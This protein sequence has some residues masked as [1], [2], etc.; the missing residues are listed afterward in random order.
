MSNVHMFERPKQPPAIAG[1]VPPHNLDAE[2][3]VLSTLMLTGTKHLDDVG[4]VLKSAD[5]YGEANGTVFL[6]LQGLQKAG[7]PVDVV[8]VAGWLR[9][10]EK[11]PSCGGV[12]YLHK[13]VDA[14]P[15][16]ANVMAYARDV[17]I[18][19]RRRQVISEAHAIAAEGY[20]DVGDEL[21][22]IDQAEQ[23]MARLAEGHSTKELVTI[24]N[25]VG[26]YFTRFQ[27]SLEPGAKAP[28]GGRF[29][30]RSLDRML[31]MLEPGDVTIVGGFPGDGKT[32]LGLQA[33]IATAEERRDDP[34]G[35]LV[36]S[37]E[38]GD[39]QLACRALFS[40][41]RLD[42]SMAKY[43]RLK[44]VGPD[45][46]SSLTASASRL[47]KLPLWIDDR[48]QVDI[49]DLPAS[50]RRHQAEAKRSGVT[51]RLVVVDYLQLL[52]GKAAG[53]NANR[54]TEVANVSRGL[55][56]LAKACGVHVIALAQLNDDS[57]KR[58]K[59]DQRPSS[60]DFRE[61]KAIWANAD[62]C[63]LIHNPMAK[64]RS[65]AIRNGERVDRV[66]DP[67]S[68]ELIVDKHRGGSTG[69]VN[70]LFIPHLTRFEEPISDPGYPT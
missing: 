32:S 43:H 63:V 24:G 18:K 36:I 47:Y 7:Q 31:G 58:G 23:R 3:A 37:A 60:K 12:A 40:E 67:E 26:R 56:A 30:L 6:A 33:A 64:E 1:R 53:R 65:R 11:L 66:T 68:V 29:G 42:S 20:G 8:Q 14:A 28:A 57:S 9:D 44:E 41:A 19:A 69:T 46:W 70:M 50:V 35:A 27:A 2:A 4:S 17:A 45:T 59:D 61:S 51:I 10:R 21:A 22:W 62:K 25:A 48:A 16:V 55:K 49:A 38:M 54:E 13:L 39:E 5:F 15:E 34:S 52:T